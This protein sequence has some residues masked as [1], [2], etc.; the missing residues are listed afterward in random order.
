MN[1]LYKFFLDETERILNETKI[2]CDNRI[3]KAREG[4]P[5]HSDIIR[6][7]NVKEL[8]LERQLDLKSVGRFFRDMEKEYSLNNQLT[9]EM[10]FL[11]CCSKFNI[12][13]E[14]HTISLLAEYKANE[15]LRTHC[16]E[17]SNYIS[18]NQKSQSNQHS[19]EFKEK[20]KNQFPI[21]QK[22][23]Q[24]EFMQ[25]LEALILLDRIKPRP[26]QTKRELFVEI[27]DFFGLQLS[28]NAESNLGK[29]RKTKLV[30]KLFDDLYQMW[31]GRNKNL[32]RK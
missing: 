8:D 24:T 4:Y 3:S 31:I 21:W 22:T 18:S 28:K 14:K 23:N 17:L 11:N 6:E 5:I 25:L 30:P 13:G 32:E 15:K 2:A 16:Y 19:S 7:L 1:Q 29:G 10:A 20:T 9:E 27:A 26:N 12:I